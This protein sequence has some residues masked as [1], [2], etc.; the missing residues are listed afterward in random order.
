M[1]PVPD[2][3]QASRSSRAEGV[4]ASLDATRALARQLAALLEPGF[5]LYLSGDLGAGKTTLVRELL[6]ALGHTGRVASPTFA[7][8]EPYNLSRFELHHFDFYRLNN[9]DAW[10]DAGF[11]ESFDG[12]AVVIV[13]WPEQAGNGLPTPDLRIELRGDPSLADN[14]RLL[15]IEAGG[16]RGHACLSALRDAGFCAMARSPDSDC[17]E[18]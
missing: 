18:R 8:M 12:Q 6:R 16:A 7:L 1:S 15:V 11:E 5:R 13:E 2:P 10:R 9:P 3:D 17:A 4:L 14:E